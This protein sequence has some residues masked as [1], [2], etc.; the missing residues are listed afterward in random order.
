MAYPREATSS[1]LIKSLK[2]YFCIYGVPENFS[3]DDGSQFRSTA[4]RDFLKAWGTEHRVSSSYHPH[5]NLR[6]ETAVKSC[7]RLLMDNTRSDGSP[8]MDKVIRALMQH[9][10][11]PDTEYKL[12]PAQLV[13]GRPIR[14]FL[15]IRPGQYSP[16]EV[17]VNC[18]DT[19]ELAH[20][21]RFLR[22]AERW[23]RNTR[24]LKPLDVGNKVL[25]QNQ[26]GAG[27]IAKKWERTGQVIESLGYNKYRV[28]VDGSG[29]ISDRNR[30]FLRR[31]TPVTSTL[32]GPTPSTHCHDTPAESQDTPT[33]SRQV[34]VEPSQPMYAGN[35]PQPMYA[36]S[37]PQ[38]MYEGRD[39]EANGRNDPVQL[40]NEPEPE[41]V[42]QMPEPVTQISEPDQTTHSQVPLRRSVR[43]NAGKPPARYSPSVFDL[44]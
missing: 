21:E 22:G 39:S 24:D 16:S 28:K 38:P 8:N 20:R 34:P 11:T 40:V 1:D 41:P 44:S 27:K 3:S 15:P 5:S 6:A 25:I 2:E 13:F 19:R 43:A 23:S 33:V 14:D 10:N 26:R 4:F 18:R 42:T 35:L 36:G 7:K 29:R 31:I 30:Q 17:W 12:S 9:R 32:P 37:L